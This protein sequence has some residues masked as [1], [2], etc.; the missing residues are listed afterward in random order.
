[1]AG[2]QANESDSSLGS[3]GDF[4]TKDN[5]FAV[6]DEFYEHIKLADFKEVLEI[7]CESRIMSHIL[8][9]FV[10]LGK[11]LDLWKDALVCQGSKNE[12]GETKSDC[13]YLC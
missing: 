13:F 1:M 6:P 4:D 10:D 9:F 8:E 5:I 2:T 12:Q 7:Y 11:Y 3:L